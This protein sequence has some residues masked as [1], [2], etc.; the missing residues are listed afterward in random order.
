MG[1]GP[2]L[3]PKVSGQMQLPSMGAGQTAGGHP[4]RVISLWMILW[5]SGSLLLREGAQTTSDIATFVF[6]QHE[7]L[8]PGQLHQAA[9]L[10]LL[11]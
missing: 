4:T 7:S 5:L 1:M 2:C 11:H 9:A 8:V 10:T 6:M 3:A